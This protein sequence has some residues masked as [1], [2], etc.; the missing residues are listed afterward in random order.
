MKKINRFRC[1]TGGWV[2]IHS[3]CVFETSLARARVHAC[4]TE[5]SSLGS[6]SRKNRASREVSLGSRISKTCIAKSF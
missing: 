3:G 6:S 2:R 1:H 4:V 5:H